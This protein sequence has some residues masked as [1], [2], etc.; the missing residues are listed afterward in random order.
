MYGRPWS[1]PPVV[2][3]CEKRSAKAMDGAV[4]SIAERRVQGGARPVENRPALLRA[5]M[6]HYRAGRFSTGRRGGKDRARRRQPAIREKVAIF[7]IFGAIQPDINDWFQVSCWAGLLILAA[8]LR[9]L[10]DLMPAGKD[11]DV[12]PL[13]RWEGVT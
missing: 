8:E 13:W 3:K 9:P 4:M 2:A 5:V 11:V 12:F 6:A 10:I 7:Q 1:T